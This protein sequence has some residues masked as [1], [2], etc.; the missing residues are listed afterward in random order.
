[1]AKEEVTQSKVYKHWMEVYHKSR[2]GGMNDVPAK[3][4]ATRDTANHFGLPERDVRVMKQS[5]RRKLQRNGKFDHKELRIDLEYWGMVCPATLI[6]QI[7]EQQQAIEGAIRDMTQARKR[8]S[9]LQANNVPNWVR[10]GVKEGI[11]ALISELK[12][13]YPVALCPW[14]KLDPEKRDACSVC[15]GRGFISRATAHSVP[16]G[17]FDDRTTDTL[18]E[19]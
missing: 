18:R 2:R 8:L 11:S 10:A 12:G 13:C 19:L 7:A 16:N 17:V 15:E 4:Q 9:N 5:E 14:C 3:G 6:P 1:M